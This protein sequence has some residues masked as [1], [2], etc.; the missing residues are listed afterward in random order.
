MTTPND[1][2]GA[3]APIRRG[4]PRVGAEPGPSPVVKGSISADEFRLL[5]ELKEETDFNTSALVRD[6]ILL[7]LARNGK[8]QINEDAWEARYR[9]AREVAAERAPVKAQ[10]LEVQESIFRAGLTDVDG[11]GK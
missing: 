9:L 11:D 5:A 1:S 10:L 2:G 3:G 7:L 8:L 6:G 4:R